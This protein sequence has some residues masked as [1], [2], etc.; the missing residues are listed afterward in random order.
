MISLVYYSCI[1]TGKGSGS[2]ERISGKRLRQTRGAKKSASK[3]RST[4]LDVSG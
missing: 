4:V 2:G 1:T 3:Q